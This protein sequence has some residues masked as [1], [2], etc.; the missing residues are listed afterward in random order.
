MT[1]LWIAMVTAEAE[2]KPPEPAPVPASVP[3]GGS[4]V[5]IQLDQG[6]VYV[7]A[8]GPSLT[9]KRV[10][11]VGIGTPVC[12]GDTSTN[13][14]WVMQKF[15]ATESYWLDQ[16]LFHHD[17]NVDPATD[18]VRLEFRNNKA[19]A[20]SGAQVTV[21]VFCKAWVKELEKSTGAGSVRCWS[22]NSCA[23]PQSTWEH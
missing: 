18:K 8:S 5:P 21:E 19:I 12:G 4:T 9:E 23:T 13:E 6:T 15:S 16:G 10:G 22:T 1:G 20:P 11:V 17:T 7:Y 3:A 2:A 14:V